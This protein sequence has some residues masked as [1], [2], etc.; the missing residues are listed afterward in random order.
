[1]EWSLRQ[2]V[3]IDMWGK[4]QARSKNCDVDTAC[5]AGMGIV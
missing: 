3:K 5:A 1:M 4:F 2:E